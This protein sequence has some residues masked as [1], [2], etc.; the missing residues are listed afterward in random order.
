MNKICQRVEAVPAA[1]AAEF[2]DANEA[3]ANVP[4]ATLAKPALAHLNLFLLVYK[5]IVVGRSAARVVFF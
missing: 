2:S 4:V 5:D 3:F 1:A